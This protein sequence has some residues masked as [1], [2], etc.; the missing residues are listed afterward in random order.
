M[1]RRNFLKGAA[2]AAGLAFGAEPPAHATTQPIRKRP[3]SKVTA[4][5]GTELFVKD[6]GHGR[7][8]V[9]VHSLATDNNIWQY[10]H[11]H[12][13]DAGFRVVTFDRRG[14]GRSSEPGEGY[15]MDTL[16]DDL[17]RVIAGRDLSAITLIGHSMGCGEIVRYLSRHGTARVARIALVAGTTP[18]LLKAPGNPE[19]VDG[20]AFEQLR[21]LWRK[22]F[23]AWVVAN[24]KPFFVPETSQA[25]VDWGIAMMHRTPPHV[26][27]ACNKA[28]VEADFRAELRA[29][30]L[31]ILIIHGSHDAS[32]PIAL[33]G[34]RTAAL[35]PHGDYRVY[36][37]APHGLML[38]H[39][40]RL[41]DDLRTFAQD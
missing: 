20:A 34:A 3:M 26:A 23:P 28:M 38:T 2:L 33:T 1:M 41:N 29:L 19:G 25:T 6:W 36:D 35:V 12:F 22:D 5:D 21:S 40:D 11:E 7:P 39:M 24:A 17:A 14:H 27:I 16:A 4:A 32:A 37:G 13:L 30:K 15:D 31:P 10:Q 8:V 9:F 18:C